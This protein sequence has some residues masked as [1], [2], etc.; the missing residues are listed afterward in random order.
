MA[1][2]AELGL[3]VPTSAK[4]AENKI[5]RQR[6]LSKPCKVCGL[7]RA[8][9]TQMARSLVRHPYSSKTPSYRLTDPFVEF[10]FDGEWID[11]PMSMSTGSK[12]YN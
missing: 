1:E 9:T 5:S 11:V 8:G 2:I 10:C 12:F 6:D 7:A 3:S 4:A